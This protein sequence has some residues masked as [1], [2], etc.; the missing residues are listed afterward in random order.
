MIQFD[1]GRQLPQRHTTFQGVGQYVILG[2]LHAVTGGAPPAVSPQFRGF[3]V[4]V[5][6]LMRAG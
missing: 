2:Q 4:N 3:L 1:L 5:G 6:R